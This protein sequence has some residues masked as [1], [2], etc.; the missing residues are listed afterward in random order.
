MGKRLI[1]Y[2]ELQY[3]NQRLDKRI[4]DIRVAVHEILVQQGRAVPFISKNKAY[5]VYGR[6]TV[7]N[8]IKWGLLPEVK[9]GEDN[10]RIRLEVSRLIMLAGTSNRSEYFEHER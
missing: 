8:W 2:D 3:M 9:D 6:K 4:S 7:D 5:E 1:I 10:C